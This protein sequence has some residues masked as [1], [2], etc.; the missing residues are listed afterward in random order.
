[1][2]SFKRTNREEYP[3]REKGLYNEKNDIKVAKNRFFGY[4]NLATC[5]MLIFW[6]WIMKKTLWK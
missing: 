4:G 2:L 3:R 5:K 6:P 1:M